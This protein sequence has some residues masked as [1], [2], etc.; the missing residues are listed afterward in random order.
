MV[1]TQMDS[2][3]TRQGCIICLLQVFVFAVCKVR[4]DGGVAV[5][6]SDGWT[7]LL[8]LSVGN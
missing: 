3:L 8:S 5:R 6:C 4:D 1:R 2:S 7:H